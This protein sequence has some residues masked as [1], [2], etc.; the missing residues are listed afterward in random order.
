[1]KKN[2]KNINLKY[3][4]S[5][6]I[7]KNTHDHFSIIMIAGLAILFTLGILSLTN[8]NLSSVTGNAINTIGRPPTTPEYLES[9]NVFYKDH[10]EWCTIS[11]E[12]KELVNCLDNAKQECINCVKMSKEPKQWQLK[13]YCYK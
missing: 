2:K 10:F 3:D 9:C 13:K 4:K 7:P 5:I 6:E 1:M 11:Y 12:N 8:Q